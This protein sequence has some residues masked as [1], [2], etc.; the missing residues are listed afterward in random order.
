MNASTTGAISIPVT[1]TPTL[2]ATLG[3]DATTAGE[4]L[5]VQFTVTATVTLTVLDRTPVTITV[6][7]VIAGVPTT[8]YSA[9]E[10]FPITPG[11]NS[12]VTVNG[13]DFHPPAGFLVYQ[14]LISSPS[15]PIRVGPESMIA[16]AYSD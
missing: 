4:N 7:R 3:L 8:I 2:F 12:I 16:S 10:V 1:D 11:A 6:Q 13:A 15:S 14:A 5:E 9:T